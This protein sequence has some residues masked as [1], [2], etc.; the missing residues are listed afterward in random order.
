MGP[1]VSL[2]GTNAAPSTSLSWASR[3]AK[4]YCPASVSSMSD[5]LRLA[6][7][8]GRGACDVISIALLL[9]ARGLRG[10]VHV[11]TGTLC[12]VGAAILCDIALS[13]AGE[14]GGCGQCVCPP[15]WHITQVIVSPR[16]V[17]RPRSGFCYQIRPHMPNQPR[18]SLR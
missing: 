10:T 2:S 3:E 13:A 8:V 16:G 12:A 6:P 14:H 15:R 5:R 4:S 7:Q 11:G 17:T 1:T 18:V 9:C